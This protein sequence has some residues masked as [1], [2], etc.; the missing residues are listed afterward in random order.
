V[1]QSILA[2]RALSPPR[3]GRAQGEG[4]LPL[5]SDEFETAMGVI[6]TIRIQPFISG[7]VLD[8]QRRHWSYGPYCNDLY[9]NEVRNLPPLFV[10]EHEAMFAELVE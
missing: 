9:P 10:E 8:P 3:A 6:N 4:A 7:K 1:K 2:A 5:G